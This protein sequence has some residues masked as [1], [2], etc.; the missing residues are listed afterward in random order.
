MSAL[1][2]RTDQSVF[3]RWWWTIDRG[4]LA[5]LLTLMGFGVVLVAASSPPVAERINLDQYHFI[6]RH[7][8]YLIPALLIM[9]GVSFLSSK[10]IFFDFKASF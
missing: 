1:F 3:G 7:L 4:M 6:K 5:A 2:S 8:V 9:L 10:N